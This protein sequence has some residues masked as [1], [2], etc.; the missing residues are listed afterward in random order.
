MLRYIDYISG[1]L[2]LKCRLKPWP[3]QPDGNVDDCS[4][5]D[6][7]DDGDDNDGDGVDVDDEYKYTYMIWIFH[8]VVRACAS[9]Y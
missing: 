2:S 9:A 5:N 6:S 4:D 8:Q 3:Q 7:D 1:R